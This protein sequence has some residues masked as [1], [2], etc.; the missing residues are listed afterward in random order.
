M[1]F[2]PDS[3]GQ[4]TVSKGRATDRKL[5]DEWEDW[6][7]TPEGDIDEPK[8]RF[9]ALATGIFVI[10][11]G[12]LLLGAY[13]VNPRLAQWPSHVSVPL[14]WGFWMALGA[15]SLIYLLF[16]IEAASGKAR[17]LPYRWSE[18]LLLWLLPKSVWLGKRLGL[19]R[20]RVFNSFIKVNNVLSR[21]HTEPGRP[22]K[23][24]VLLP[25]CLSRE[26]RQEI[27][28]IMD[29]RPH[30]LATAGGGEEA[31]KAIRKERPDFIIALA[32]ERDLAS[33]I[34][35]VA[36]HVPVIGIPN[37]RPEG[38][39]KNTCVD[40]DEFRQALEFFESTSGQLQEKTRTEQK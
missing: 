40:I 2:E 7:G 38:P 34:K 10:F 12:L 4:T 13:L 29:G 24:L 6:D 37:K 39:C 35:D 8:G 5:G 16:V 19:S 26:T 36:L 27:R 9:I 28:A 17:I 33:G 23:L 1:T 11:L 21:A 3:Q 25:R 30:A 20:D 31:R 32:C 22:R 18:A 15:S 14:R